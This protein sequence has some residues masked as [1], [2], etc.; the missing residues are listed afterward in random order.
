MSDNPYQS[1]PPSAFDSPPRAIGVHSGNRNDLRRVAI[2][3]KGIIGCIGVYLIALVLQVAFP[4]EIRL[5]LALAVLLVIL[6]GTVFVFLLAMKVYQP[7]VGILLGV[8]TLFP[9][10]G[11]IALL[12]VNAKATAILKQNGIHV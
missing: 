12:V 9:C 4:P 3:Q 7:V 11:L 8:L 2:Y 5:F 1:P 10:I 6:T